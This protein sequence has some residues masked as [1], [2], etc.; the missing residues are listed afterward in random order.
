MFHISQVNRLSVKAGGPA[1]KGVFTIGGLFAKIVHRLGLWVVV[2][3]DYPSLIKGGHNT[4]TVRAEPDM[5]YSD[6]E[7]VDVL[8]AVDNDT[9]RLHAHELSNDGIVI[10]DSKALKGLEELPRED[11]RYLDIP[12]SEIIKETGGARYEN[13]VLLGATCAVFGIDKDVPLALM[14][15]KFAKKGE[16][17]LANNRESFN[18]GY[19]AAYAQL[20]EAPFKI[21]IEPIAHEDRRLLITGNDAAAVG[22]IKAGVKLIAEYPMTPSSSILHFMAAHEEDRRI[23]VKHTEDELAAINILIGGSV[24]GLRV[25]TAT[26]GGGFALMNEGLGFAALAEAPVVILESMRSGPSTGMPTYTDQG[27]LLYALH[28]SQGEFPRVVLT[29]GDVTESFRYGFEAFN[30]AE[31]LQVPVILLLD[32]HISS[33]TF[34]TPRFETAD[35]SVDRGWLLKDGE[36]AHYLDENGKFKRHMLT[37]SGISPRAIPG[38]AQGM[39]VASSYEH[40]ETGYTSEDARNRELQMEKRFRKLDQLDRE[41]IRPTFY[42]AS[43]EE[44]DI[45][46]VSWGSNKGA[47]LEAMKFLEQEDKNVRFMHISVAWPLDA[48]T[49]SEEL[50]AAKVSA[51]V[52]ATY[53]GQMGRLIRAETGKAT[54]HKILKYDGRPFTPWALRSRIVELIP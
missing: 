54:N 3:Q 51:L 52:E 15:G 38:Q 29:P 9:I 32:K 47:I 10:V 19:D 31:R 41:F 42:G 22:A 16:Q 36:A 39:Y 53:T 50:E 25:M 5:I 23:L 13:T 12:V 40:D 45:L 24:A 49:I 27:D 33:S 8:I 28:A 46:I 30:I 34:S 44:A 18:R 7:L 6:I 35:L 1:G 17:V 37:D 4:I 14:E 2:T 43:R 11:I 26:S 20:E 21:R 48:E